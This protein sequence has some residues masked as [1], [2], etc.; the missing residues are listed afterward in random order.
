MEWIYYIFA[1]IIGGIIAASGLIVAKAPNAQSAINKL[2]PYKAFIGV[3]LLVLGV[4]NLIANIGDLVAY[5]KVDFLF[6]LTILL[7]IIA[8]LLLGFL[9]GMPQIAKWI[10][11]DSPAEQKAVDMQ[12]KIVPFEVPI[13]L[14]GIA[15]GLLMLLYKLEILSVI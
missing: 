13:G 5:F 4:L 1:P 6:G 9:L 12:K 15:A 8:E 11:G 14:I 10:P 2:L 7:T 3:G